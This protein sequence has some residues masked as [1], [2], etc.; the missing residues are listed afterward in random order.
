MHLKARVAF[1][2]SIWIAI[3]LKKK[4]FLARLV[5]YILNLQIKNESMVEN[6]CNLGLLEPGLRIE[7]LQ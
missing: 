3:V 4:N 2:R 1:T 5:Y 6:R 7:V